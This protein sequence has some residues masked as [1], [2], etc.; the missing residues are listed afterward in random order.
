MARKIL[1]QIKSFSDVKDEI[2]KKINKNKN[3]I[4]QEEVFKAF[5]NFDLS[6]NES[7][8]FFEELQEK[9]VIFTDLETEDE[10]FEE[11][12]NMNNSLDKDEF[13]LESGDYFDSHNDFNELNE[14]DSNLDDEIIIN[15]KNN[16]PGISN[17]TKT[18]D[19]TKAYFYNLGGS[20][21]L[22]KEEEIECAKM[23]ESKNPKIRK[24]GFNKLVTSNLRLVISVAKKHTNRGLEFPELFQEGNIGLMRAVSKFDYRRGFKFSTY[25][26]WWIRQ[27]VTRA[28]ADQARTIRIPVHMVETINKLTR[29]E[30]QLTQELGRDPSYEE[31]AAGLGIL[32]MTAEKVRDIK[33][34]AMEPVSLEKPIGEEDDTQFADFVDDKEMLSPTEFAEKNSLKEQLDIIF[35][36]TLN[37]REQKVI[38][39]RFGVLPTTL[40]PLIQLCE[41]G[42][43]KEELIN[44][45]KEHNLTLRTPIEKILS[46][47]NPIFN[48]HIDKY[49]SPKTLEDVG[50]EFGVTRER[51]RQ[52]EAKGCRKLKSP[53]KSRILRDFYKG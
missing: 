31:I 8:D 18:Q 51:I 27:A 19:I 48:K 14:E 50:T 21:I 33:R 42:W 3:K 9:G 49:N 52:I 5:E 44:E 13:S 17:D 1:K 35:D 16:A 34:L 24:K 32:G 36:E 26:T 40:A 12:A 20:K 41:D 22:T 38:R 4:T 39:M 45:M 43:E 25:A 37:K 47:D 2:W 23:L 11:F 53:A 46:L 10:D 6:E 7:N 28:I 15:Y 30:R 29:T